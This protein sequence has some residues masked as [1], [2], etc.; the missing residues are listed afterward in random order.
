MS[1]YDPPAYW[2]RLLGR[3]A[4]LRGVGFPDLALTF[5]RWQ[6]RARSA[7]VRAVVPELAGARVLDVGSG[8][9]Y[10]IA[11]WRAL[12]AAEVCGIDLTV[13]AV[14][15]LRAAFPDVRFERA[16]VS[17]GVP[18]SGPF[19]V[20]SAMDVLL[21]IT[22]DERY[23]RALANLRGAA[24]PGTRLVLLEPVALGRPVPFVPGSH[25]R[26]RAVGPVGDA[27]ARSGWTLR[28]VRPA[29]WLLNSPIELDPPR[30]YRWLTLYWRVVSRPARPE[31]LAEVA[32][33]IAYPL[34]RL[35][36]RTGWGPSSKVV[37]AEAR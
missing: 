36:C 20:I 23:G 34:D 12:G 8:T 31:L 22:D 16:D 4:D 27:L 13:A 2:E 33:A 29:T 24:R 30:L 35:L 3:G 5:N 18:V 11:L 25:S 37:V 19:D 9:G 10:W 15:R 17:E 7:S 6:Y 26:A 32:G 21:H 1:H 14:E 28:S